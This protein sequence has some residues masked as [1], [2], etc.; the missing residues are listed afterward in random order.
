MIGYSTL[1][2]QDLARAM[3]FY[4]PL[5]EAMDV[6]L[7]WHTEEVACWGD[8]DA[9]TAPRFFVGLPYDEKPASAGNGSMTAFLCGTPA[10]IDRLHAL[11]LQNGG[12]DEGAPGPRPHYGDGFYAAYVRDPDGNKLAFVNYGL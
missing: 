4:V 12:Q 5:F 9:P 1:G 8:K 6:A 7:K 10:L 2:T 3:R 11:A